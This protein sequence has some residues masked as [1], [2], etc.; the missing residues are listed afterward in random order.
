LGEINFQLSGDRQTQVTLIKVQPGKSSGTG[1][2]FVP[3]SP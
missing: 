2:D 1:Y 3:V